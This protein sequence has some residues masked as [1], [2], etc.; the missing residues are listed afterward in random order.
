MIG[1]DSDRQPRSRV[2]Q[3]RVFDSPAAGSPAGTGTGAIGTVGGA[4]RLGERSLSSHRQRSM[5]VSCAVFVI[6]TES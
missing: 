5:T 4:V 2:V 6:A 1:T 3:P